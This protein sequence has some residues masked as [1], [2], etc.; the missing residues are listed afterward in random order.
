MPVLPFGYKCQECGQGTVR[1]RV[2][3]EYKTKLKGYP[4]TVEEAHV[5][6]CDQCGAQHFDPNETIRWRTLLSERQA[7]SYLQP[8]DIR[9]LQNLLG[10]TREQFAILLGCTR[11]SLYNWERPDRTAPQSRMADLFMR[12][13]R[14]SHLVG[15]INVL[16]F[17]TSEAAKLGFD[18]KVPPRTHR[19]M[20]IVTIA[21]KTPLKHP[22]SDVPQPLALAADT[23]GVTEEVILETEQK[24]PIARLFYDY[25]EGAL[26]LALLETVQ[27]DEFDA[28]IQFKD[29]T[30]TSGKDATIKDG[31][32]MLLAQTTRTAED[33]DQVRFFPHDLL[34]RSG[35]K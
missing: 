34:S 30:Q 12:L 17:V 13:I 22:S 26:K 8:V 32:A 3:H 21:R 23:D 35:R 7:E 6:V 2:F 10:L 20:P 27:F 33:V 1:E 31:E 16:N 28:E 19:T 18:L 14:Q 4:L 9:N 5:G 15:E 25:L 24:Q 11:Q 29:G